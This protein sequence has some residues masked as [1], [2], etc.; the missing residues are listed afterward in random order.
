MLCKN[1]LCDSSLWHLSTCSWEPIVKYINQQY[2]QYLK[3]ELHVNRKRPIP[4]SRVHCCIYFLPAT[5]HRFLQ[6]TSLLK[7][8][9]WRRKTKNIHLMFIFVL[10]LSFTDYAPSI[11]NSWSGWEP[12]WASCLWLR[13]LTL[14]PSQRERTSKKG[15][16]TDFTIMC[17]IKCQ[18]SG[19]LSTP[20][21]WGGPPF[22]W[23]WWA[24]HT[25]LYT[26][27]LMALTSIIWIYVQ[28]WCTCLELN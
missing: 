28:M 12:L 6:F 14:S 25:L 24:F 22:V 5:G 15:L 1:L 13:R 4:D 3:E 18:F 21:Q 17:K 7:K 9:S 16:E 11:L 23:F 20:K 2:E 10:F 8:I 26:N 19:A 27:N